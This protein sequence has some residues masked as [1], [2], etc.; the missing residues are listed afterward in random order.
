MINAEIHC[1]I[2]LKSFV[3]KLVPN[4]ECPLFVANDFLILDIDEFVY[5]SSI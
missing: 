1:D 2:V 3:P 5:E 4:R